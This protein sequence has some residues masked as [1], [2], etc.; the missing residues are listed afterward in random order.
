MDT[1]QGSVR[2]AALCQPARNSPAAWG[3]RPR[4]T[5]AATARPSKASAKPATGER[6]PC[7]WELAWSWLRLQPDSALSQWYNRRFAQG[8]RTRRVGIVALARRLAIAL[9][10][11]LERGDTPRRS[12]AQADRRLSPRSRRP[13]ALTS[14]A[15]IIMIKGQRARNG[16]GSLRSD[17]PERWGASVTGDCQRTLRACCIGYRMRTSGTDRSSFEHWLERSSHP[18]LGS[19]CMSHVIP[20]L[21]LA[22]TPPPAVPE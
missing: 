14:M 10:R 11:Y 9:W 20:Q 4:P 1:G 18:D 5:P 17:R 21:N 22:V 7:W 6:A 12:R 16:G 3:W 19:G 13:N 8:K 15:R 2:L